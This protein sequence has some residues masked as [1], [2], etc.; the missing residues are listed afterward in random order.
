MICCPGSLSPKLA[1]SN[2]KSD[3]SAVDWF[4]GLMAVIDAVFLP[5]LV[6]GRKYSKFDADSFGILLKILIDF[7]CENKIC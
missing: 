1:A 6:H 5:Q 2:S 4:D 3:G 7:F